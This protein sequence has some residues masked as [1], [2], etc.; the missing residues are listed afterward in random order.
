MPCLPGRKESRGNQVCK[1]SRVWLGMMGLSGHKE[2]KA[3][4][5]RPGRK[6]SQEI[7][8]ARQDRRVRQVPTERTALMEP[9]GHLER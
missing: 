5:A 3:S 8:A 4:K 1:E 9:K 2:S 6:E 7:Q